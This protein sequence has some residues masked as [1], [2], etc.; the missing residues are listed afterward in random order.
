MKSLEEIKRLS[1]EI[2]DISD[3]IYHVSGKRLTDFRKEYPVIHDRLYDRWYSSYDPTGDPS[4]QDYDYSVYSD[5]DYIFVPLDCFKVWSRPNVINTIKYFHHI[6]HEPETILD[7]FA[8]TGQSSVLLALAFPGSKVRYFNSDEMQVKLFDTLVERYDIKNVEILEGPEPG[9]ELVV[10]YEAIEHILEPIEFMTP[11]LSDQ[12]TKFYVDASSFTLDSIGHFKNYVVH[13]KHPS[14]D[15]EINRVIPNKEF[16]RFYFNWVKSIG[17][18]Q[19]FDTQLEGKPGHHKRFYNG[20]PNVFTR[21][22]VNN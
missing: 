7:I 20:R 15:D 11:I 13:I 12:R 5:P 19:S 6:N 1:F 4:S 21:W 17:F 2:S 9:S 10:A 22:N 18:Y 8:G 16:K 14:I 3:D